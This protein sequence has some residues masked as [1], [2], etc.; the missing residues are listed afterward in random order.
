MPL[1]KLSFLIFS[2][3]LLAGV[4]L[5]TCTAMLVS[6]NQSVQT[7]SEQR[8]RSYLL[9]DELR[10]SSDDL[11]R[12]ARTYVITQDPVHEKEYWHVLAVR[13]GERP[14]AD[15]R[16]VPLRELMRQ[17]GFT[18]R[19]FALLDES[20]ANSDALVTTETIAM[21]AVKGLYDDGNGRYVVQRA[22]DLEMARRIMHDVTYHNNK[23]T[24]MEPLKR[25]EAL[26]DGRTLLSVEKNQQHAARLL[27]V[28]QAL[29]V[30]LVIIALAGGYKAYKRIV[31]PTIAIGRKL[32]LLGQGELAFSEIWDQRNAATSKNE[33]DQLGGALGNLAAYMKLMAAAADSLAQ[34]D[35]TINV[36]PR[37]EHD[38]LGNS[39]AH[40]TANLRQ[41]FGRLN[42]QAALLGKASSHLSIVSEQVTASMSGVSANAT[43]VAAAAEQMSV[44]MKS[45]TSA[46]E[47]STSNIESV[48][49]ATEE[50]TATIGEIAR[51]SEQSRQVAGSAVAT[52]ESAAHGVGDLS[53]AAEA[54]GRVLEVISD[55]AEQTKLLALNATIEAASAG[56]AGKG[57]AVVAGEVKELARRTSEATEEIR[58]SIGS[59]QK[60]AGSTVREIGEIRGVIGEVNDNVTT[61]AAAVEEQA[62]TTRAIAGNVTDAARGVSG[63]SDSVAE[64]AKAAGS[65]AAEITAV[66]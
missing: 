39:F 20:Q 59:I 49:T 53:K 65:I 2:G 34:G 10:Q 57:F 41:V 66:E 21:N 3:I 38:A 44:N 33:V 28:A 35:L 26:V 48:A 61:I 55:I 58:T 63:A 27:F 62:T 30:F 42:E 7:S 64:S 60:T 37:S 50:M 52:V 22:P 56:D 14:R 46:T 24:I 29:V 45:V 16:T 15:G 47:Q 11:T 8:F 25:F 13:N 9:A 19:E 54:V 40:M 5:G 4:L 1:K 6:S 23:A 31:Q 32:T 36:E 17:A 51:S 12:L 43:S 18:D